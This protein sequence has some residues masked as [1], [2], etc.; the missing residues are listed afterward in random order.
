MSS[1]KK[2]YWVEEAAPLLEV[3]LIVGVGGSL[4]VV[5]GKVSR[6]P[7]W[8]QKAGLEWFFRFLQEPRRMWRRYTVTNVRFV[9]LVAAAM[10]GRL[11]GG[12][13]RPSADRGRRV[14]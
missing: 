1:P 5:A 11:L 9:A 13:R 12:A 14:S 3:P 8:M 4:D 7:A 2:E 10:W 6:A